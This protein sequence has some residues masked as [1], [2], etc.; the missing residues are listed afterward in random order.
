MAISDFLNATPRS[1]Q[2]TPN[3][4]EDANMF[5][6]ILAAPFRGVEGAVQS[7]YDL[8]DFAT[9]DDILPD[10][11]T[12]FLGRSQTFMGGMVEVLVSL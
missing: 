1:T 4:Q 3:P 7:L 11:D 8:A 5:T 12:R 6:D 9:G 2:P 10:Y